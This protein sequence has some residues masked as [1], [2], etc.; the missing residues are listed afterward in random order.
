MCVI[1][2]CDICGKEVPICC[3]KVEAKDGGVCKCIDCQERK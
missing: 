1:V 2:R 3:A